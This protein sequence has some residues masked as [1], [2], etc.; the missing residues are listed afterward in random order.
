[1]TYADMAQDAE[2]DAG[3]DPILLKDLDFTDIYIPEVGREAMMRGLAE[4]E[5]PLYP[6]DMDAIQD[7]AQV[8]KRVALQGQQDHEFVL[9]HDGVRYRVAKIENES[10]AVWYALRRSIHPIPRLREQLRHTNP[11]VIQELGAIGKVPRRGLI[12][13][14]G[15]TGAGKTTTLCSLM[16]EYLTV[17]GNLAITIE[18]PPELRLEGY[19]RN[20]SGRCMQMRVKDGDFFTP[21]K[22]VLRMAPRYILVGEIRDPDGAAEA[23]RAAISGH[24]VLATIHSGSIPEAIQSM[25]KLVSSVLDLDLAGQMLAE[26]LAAVMHQEMTRIATGDGKRVERK[27][28]LSTLFLGDGSTP[29][30]SG[31]REKIR[32]RKLTGLGDDIEGQATRMQKGQAPLALPTRD[33]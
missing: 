3:Y 6:V 16:Q 8:F 17:Y 21:L 19:Y 18:D 12:L 26:G 4:V 33:K 11:R 31:I 9:D 24:V 1:M 28:K 25:Y 20:G 29:G 27:I 32:N 13:L 2:Q 7:L 23:L 30:G 22:R 10:G 14:A 15:A 5:D